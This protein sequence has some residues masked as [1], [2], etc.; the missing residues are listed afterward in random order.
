MSDRLELLLLYLKDIDVLVLIL[1]STPAGKLKKALGIKVCG[2]VAFP[3]LRPQDGQPWFPFNG[4]V[5][6]KMY[7]EKEDTHTG[8]HMEAKFITAVSSH[9]QELSYL[10]CV[11]FDI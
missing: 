9:S 8:Y 6:G 10:L 7:V 2:E 5:T 3:S 1:H 4:P 11:A